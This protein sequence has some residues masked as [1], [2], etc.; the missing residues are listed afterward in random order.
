VT[1]KNPQPSQGTV[2]ATQTPGTWQTPHTEQ[3]T[4]LA[5]TKDQHKKLIPHPNNNNNK[6]ALKY[7]EATCGND[8]TK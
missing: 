7:S 6:G 5:H 4:G 3:A 8:N 2:I 1:T